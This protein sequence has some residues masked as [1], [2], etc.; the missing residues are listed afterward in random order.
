MTANLTRRELICTGGVTLALAATAC[1]REHEAEADPDIS[2]N[3]DL[4]REHGV[5]ERILVIYDASALRLDHGDRDVVDPIRAAATITR[6]FVESYHERTEEKYLFPELER[7]HKLDDLVA[8]LR[9]QHDAG[10]GLTDRIMSLAQTSL[11]DGRDRATMSAALRAYGAMFR[12]HIAREDTVVFPAFREVAGS[13]Y[14]E[15]GDKFED[16]ERR[17]LGKDGYDHFLAKLPAIE[18][19]AGV[20]DLGRFTITLEDLDNQR[21]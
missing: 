5:L 21:S 12:P 15:L 1:K 10:R 6:Q 4:M 8:V 9:R 20:A 7:A 3:E 17:A 11:A 13:A 18:T 2:P 14:A 16:E 19:A